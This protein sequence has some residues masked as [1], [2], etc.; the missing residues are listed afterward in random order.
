M[1][2]SGSPRRVPT[3]TARGTPGLRATS[4]AGRPWNGSAKARCGNVSSATASSVATGPRARPG[5]GDVPLTRPHLRPGLSARPALPSLVLW[6]DGHGRCPRE[7]L[8]GR[9]ALRPL[10]G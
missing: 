7:T 6:L 4:E 8:A 9:L 1:D 10:F 5:P 2:T 3:A